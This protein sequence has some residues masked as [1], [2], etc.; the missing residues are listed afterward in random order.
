[1]GSF[2]Y[3]S[4]KADFMLYRFFR[5]VPTADTKW[6][7]VAVSQI[8][9]FVTVILSAMFTHHACPLYEAVLTGLQLLCCVTQ[10]RLLIWHAY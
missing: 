1:M 6:L 8:G 2:V 9:M 7:S 10:I 4:L 3:C 5:F